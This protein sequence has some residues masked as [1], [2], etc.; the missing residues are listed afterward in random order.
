MRLSFQILLAM[1][2]ATILAGIAIGDAVRRSET[3]RM[4]AYF[5]DQSKATVSLLTGLTT[6]AIIVEDIPL[7]ETSLY[8]AVNRIPQLS[9]IRVWNEDRNL[10]A[11]AGP[12]V[13]PGSSEFSRYEQNVTFEGE[14]FGAISVFWSTREGVKQIDDRVF[15]VRLYSAIALI[16]LSCL[17]LAMLC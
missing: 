8:E 5:E 15:Q 7:V 13:E 9:T 6:E 16:S 14:T 12:D 11:Q 4:T 17:F 3:A 1:C 2:L 10:I